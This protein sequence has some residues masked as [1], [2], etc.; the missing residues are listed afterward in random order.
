MSVVY[1]L[2][3]PPVKSAICIFRVSGKGCLKYLS[4]LFGLS[5]FEPRKFY[6]AEMKDEGVLVDR[7]GLV[8]FSG[9]Q[10]YT[11]EDSFEVYA[12][13]SLGVMS[14]IIDVFKKITSD[15]MDLRLEAASASELAENFK[16]DEKTF[17]KYSYTL[18]S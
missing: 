15:E 10:S 13:G 17:K 1:A 9:P 5:G 3:T 12:H 2:A 16:N 11:G 4:L 18:V 6:L 7:V 14:L 8:I